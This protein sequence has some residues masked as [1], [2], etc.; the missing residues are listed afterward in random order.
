MSAF[1]DSRST[2]ISMLCFLFFSRATG[3]LRSYTSPSTR[4]RTNPD[5]RAASNS[6]WCSPFLPRT[7]GARIW[8][9]LPAGSASTWS[10]IWST[11]CCLI[12]RPHTGQWGTP[13]RA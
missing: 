2:T 10:T 5:R 9:R 13:M 7:T 8:I 12:S 3:S 1:T 4:A 11:V 6:F